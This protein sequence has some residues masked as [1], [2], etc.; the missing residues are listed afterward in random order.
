MESDMLVVTEVVDADRENRH[1]GSQQ[2]A[3]RRTQMS[4]GAQE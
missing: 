4:I 1:D 3:D 2:W